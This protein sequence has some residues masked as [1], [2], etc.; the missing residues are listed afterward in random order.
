MHTGAVAGFTHIWASTY[1]GRRWLLFGRELALLPKHVIQFRRT[2]RRHR[3]ELVHFND[4]PLIP[5]AWL[6]R[7]EG[8]P[9]VWHLRSAL[10]DGGGDRRSAFVRAAIRKLATTSIAINHDVGDVFGVGSTVVANSVDL[11]RFQPGDPQAAR[12]ALGL[13]ATRPVVSYFGFI[14]PSKGFR[15]FIEAAPGCATAASTRATSSSA[16][17]SAARSSSRPSSAAGCSSQT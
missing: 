15:E 10:P 12:E 9:V 11:E 1:R 17:P 3:F 4:S 8:L 13:S 16:A 14:Y 5:A 6:A 2:L 7:R